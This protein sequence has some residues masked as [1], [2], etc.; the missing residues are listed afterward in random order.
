MTK[1]KIPCGP[2]C[3]LRGSE[4]CHRD[5]CPYGWKTYKEEMDAYHN[6][7]QGNKSTANMAL[8]YKYDAQTRAYD[9]KRRRFK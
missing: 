8:T 1:P 7:V 6:F 2:K 5:E 9:F 3:D 4:V